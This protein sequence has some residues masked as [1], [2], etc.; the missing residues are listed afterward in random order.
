MVDVCLELLMK[1]AN[2]AVTIGKLIYPIIREAGFNT[3]DINSVEEEYEI[4]AIKSSIFVDRMLKDKNGKPTCAL[5]AKKV[6]DT[7]LLGGDIKKTLPHTLKA[8]IQYSVF[9]EGTEWRL[10]K[11]GRHYRTLYLRGQNAKRDQEYLVD[12]LKSIRER[13][14]N[15]YKSC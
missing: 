3:E 7:Y 9:T 12:F 6:G 11:E 2:E 1:K 5:Q 8:G 13:Y 14:K 10:Y 15:D 4:Q